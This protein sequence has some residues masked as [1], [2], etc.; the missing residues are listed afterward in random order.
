MQAWG[1]WDVDDWMVFDGLFSRQ[2]VTSLM[3]SR[4]EEI[5]KMLSTG[6]CTEARDNS[7]MFTL[8]K[9]P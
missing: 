2:C 6:S 7:W 1:Y 3:D 9:C 4:L 8:P 5:S